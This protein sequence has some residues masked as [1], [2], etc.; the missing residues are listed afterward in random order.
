MGYLL[1]TLLFLKER[2]WHFEGKAFPTIQEL[3]S[4]QLDSGMP[5]TTKSG[6]I[7][8]KAVE[9]EWELLND[10]IELKMKIGT[11]SFHSLKKKVNLRSFFCIESN[12]IKLRNKYKK[13]NTVAMPS[14]NSSEILSLS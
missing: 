1:I 5:V 10:D 8:K 12:F 9:R 4:R 7:L 11:V 13:C 2:G 6:A 3:V 14:L